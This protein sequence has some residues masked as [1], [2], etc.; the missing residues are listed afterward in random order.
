MLS[1]TYSWDQDYSAVLRSSKEG[2]ITV[3]KLDNFYP[4]TAVDVI[5]FSLQDEEYTAHL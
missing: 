1:L 4:G 5:N 3:S 2:Q